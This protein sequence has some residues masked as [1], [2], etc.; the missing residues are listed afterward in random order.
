MPAYLQIG[1]EHPGYHDML[2]IDAPPESHLPTRAARCVRA[3][4][5]QGKVWIV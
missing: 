4:R 1:C 5:V 2:L 3:Q